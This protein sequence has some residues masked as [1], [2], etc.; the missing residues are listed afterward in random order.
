VQRL[1]PNTIMSDS[2]RQPPRRFLRSM[3]RRVLFAVAGVSLAIGSLTAQATESQFAAQVQHE[4]HT[5]SCTV[6]CPLG[7][8]AHRR[9]VGGWPDPLLPFAALALSATSLLAASRIT[10]AITPRRPNSRSEP[11]IASTLRGTYTTPTGVA[12]VAAPRR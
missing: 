4:G 6:R 12:R 8:R 10:S 7:H 9:R 3:L 11:D 2:T 5:T 1:S